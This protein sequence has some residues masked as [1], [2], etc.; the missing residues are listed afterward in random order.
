MFLK[1][2]CLGCDKVMYYDYHLTTLI[3]IVV[4]CL[5]AFINLFLSLLRPMRQNEIEWNNL[6]SSLILDDLRFYF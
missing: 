2:C 4:I 3:I 1:E 6:F 5:F